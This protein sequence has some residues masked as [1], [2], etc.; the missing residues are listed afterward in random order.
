V[1]WARD[2]ADDQVK[3]FLVE[4][5]TPGFETKK[6]EHKV[7]LRCVQNAEI[8]LTDVVEAQRITSVCRLLRSESS[9]QALRLSAIERVCVGSLRVGRA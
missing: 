8:T 2:E 5:S 9:N 3:A 7:A 4:K 1:I 6:M